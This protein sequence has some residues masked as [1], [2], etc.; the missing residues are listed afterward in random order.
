MS[1]KA[2]RIIK[3]QCWRDNIILTNLRELSQPQ[4]GFA[5]KFKRNW[6]KIFDFFWGRL[7]F[8]WGRLYFYFI[9]LGRL[10]FCSSSFFEVTFIFFHFFFRLS[11]IFFRS[12]SIFYF[13]WGRLPFFHFFEVVFHLVRPRWVHTQICIPLGHPFLGEF[14]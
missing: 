14:K 5:P 10:H 13:L 3:F 1:W 8:F 12:S 6:E 9:F 11:S 4:E 7:H 2:L